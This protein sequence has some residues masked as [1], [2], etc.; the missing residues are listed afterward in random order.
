MTWHEPVSKWIMNTRNCWSAYIHG[1]GDDH[2]FGVEAHEGLV[3]DETVL[4]QEASLDGAQKVPVE[5]GVDDEDEHLG[6][7]IPVA[8]DGDVSEKSAGSRLQECAELTS[9]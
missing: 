2:E 6:H 4:A 5:T 1:D 9:G 8:V 3:F 7:A